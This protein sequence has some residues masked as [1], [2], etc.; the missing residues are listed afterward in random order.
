[1][2]L[3]PDKRFLVKLAL[4]ALGYG[5]LAYAASRTLEFVQATMPPDKQWMGYL[6]L[7]ATGIGALIWQFVYLQDAKGS[8]QRGLSFGLAV[9]DLLM[10]FVLVYADT[11][12]ESSANGLLTMSAE[13]LRLFILASV[14]A[15]GLNAIG[16]FF[17]KLWDPEKEQER[18]AADF[19]DEIENEAL[20]H[21]STPEIRQQ[22]IREHSPF[23]Q[24]AIMGRVA[25]NVSTR[26][27]KAIPLQQSSI[28]ANPNM[29]IV[30]LGAP[31]EIENASSAPT[32]ASTPPAAESR[33]QS[34]TAKARPQ[35]TDKDREIAASISP[36][37]APYRSCPKCDETV[38]L[39]QDQC[40]NCQTIM[41]I[42]LI[43][44]DTKCGK[45]GAPSGGQ[46][47]CIRCATELAHATNERNDRKRSARPSVPAPTRKPEP[48]PF[49]KWH[50]ETE[51]FTAEIDLYN[52]PGRNEPTVYKGREYSATQTNLKNASGVFWEIREAGKDDLLCH[53][54]SDYFWINPH[55]KFN[56]NQ[57]AKKDES[58][59]TKSP[60]LG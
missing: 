29:P 6:F 43:E 53:C 46:V 50:G 55:S 30:P 37:A 33:S 34:S 11:M 36:L 54:S 2:K 58:V 8:K 42:I 5:L 15:V 19:A 49:A 14:G 18:Q 24:S 41:P 57:P 31:Y 10:E 45:C 35:I 44:T 60:F 20:K 13:D 17:Y 22:M 39:S 52:T 23:I 9:V 59:S 40:W 21:L 7:L 1:M 48:K 16:W 12:R 51:H 32:A 27:T 56:G 26:F 47:L 28:P 38:P 4:G 3:A 25:E